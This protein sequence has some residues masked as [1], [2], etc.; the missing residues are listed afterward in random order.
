MAFGFLLLVSLALSTLLNLF[1]GWAGAWLL[2]E[3]VLLVL[4]EVMAFAVCAALFLWGSC[5]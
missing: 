4:N 1:T 2:M 3:P 5:A